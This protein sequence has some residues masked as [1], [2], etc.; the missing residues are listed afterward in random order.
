MERHIDH[1]QCWV[2]NNEHFETYRSRRKTG[3]NRILGPKRTLIDMQNR[4]RDNILPLD[5]KMQLEQK[6]INF[7]KKYHSY[8]LAKGSAY[9]SLNA[10]LISGNGPINI[11]N[12]TERLSVS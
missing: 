3:Q 9:D 5:L 6:C 2:G 11:E 4:Y 7:E 1:V 12:S 8:L 10:S